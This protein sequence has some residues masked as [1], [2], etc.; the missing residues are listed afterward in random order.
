MS[1]VK[2]NEVDEDIKE[3]NSD[4][5]NIDTDDLLANLDI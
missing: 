2:T 5:Q 3:D 1:K 4:L